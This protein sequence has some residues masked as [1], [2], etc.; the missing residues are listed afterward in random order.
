MRSI[1]W[2]LDGI[3]SIETEDAHYCV[4]TTYA[5]D[6]TLMEATVLD[7]ETNIGEV[8]E[9]VPDWVT[10]LLSGPVGLEEAKHGAARIDP[11]RSRQPSIDDSSVAG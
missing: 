11:R 6:G 7:M 10:R 1:R 2:K 9:S 3:V 5:P 4:G 8:P